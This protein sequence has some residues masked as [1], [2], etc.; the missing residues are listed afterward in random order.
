MIL[1]ILLL[2][3]WEVQKIWFYGMS[4]PVGLFKAE[5]QLNNDKTIKASRNIS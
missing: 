4:V 5:Y 2:Q 1:L 3:L